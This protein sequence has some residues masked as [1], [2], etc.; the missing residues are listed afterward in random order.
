MEDLKDLD[1]TKL[2]EKNVSNFKKLSIKVIYTKSYQIS[3]QMK[4]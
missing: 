3:N 2:V 1:I 4:F